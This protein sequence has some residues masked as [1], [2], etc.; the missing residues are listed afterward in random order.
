MAAEPGVILSQKVVV[1]GL[2]LDARIGV[3]DHEKTGAQ[4][5]LV[6]VE[7]DLSRA[8]VVGLEATFNY[9]LVVDAA[10][11]ILADGHVDLVETFAR[12]LAE[13]CIRQTAAQRVRVHVLKPQALSPFADAAGVEIVME[14]PGP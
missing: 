13:A 3:Y 2:R 5:L 1:R 9:E 14:M 10:R 12:R 4:P 7:V 11:Q 8:P 6:D